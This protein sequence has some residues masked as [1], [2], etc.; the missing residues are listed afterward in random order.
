MP[1]VPLSHVPSGHGRGLT[2]DMALGRGRG[3]SRREP[4]PLDG[5]RTRDGRAGELLRGVPRH[6]RPRA[7]AAG[8]VR[9]DVRRGR[10][11]PRRVQPRLGPDA[12]AV[13]PPD[14]PTGRALRPR[15]GPRRREPRARRRRL[16]ERLRRARDPPPRG[17]RRRGKRER[18]QR[19]GRHGL[20]LRLRPGVRARDPADGAAAGWRRGGPRPPA[21]RQRRRDGGGAA[22]ARGRVSRHRRGGG[23]RPAGGAAGRGREPRRRHS[24]RSATRACGASRSGAG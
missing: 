23:R 3:G 14:R 17:G 2:P 24:V 9:A 4:L 22:R 12:A 5:S 10:G 20:V 6:S 7:R 15:H 1:A 13:G 11:R 18:G 16:R 8:R 21:D 19:A